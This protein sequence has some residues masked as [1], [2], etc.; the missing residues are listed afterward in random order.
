ME[1]ILKKIRDQILF[2][3][4]SNSNVHEGEILKSYYYV[5]DEWLKDYKSYRQNSPHLLHTFEKYFTKSL[6]Y[7]LHT[8]FNLY[9]AVLTFPVSKKF[10][11]SIIDIEPTD[12]S[13]ENLKKILEGSLS[14]KPNIRIS[15]IEIDTNGLSNPEIKEMISLLI[16]KLQ[17]DSI[18]NLSWDLKQVDSSVFDLVYLRA[19]CLKIGEAELFYH[20]SNIFVDRLFTSEFFQEARDLCEEI[21]IASIKDNLLYYGF[22]ICFRVYSNQASVQASLLY[23]NLFLNAVLK[24]ESIASDKFQFEIIW[25]SLKFFR[26]CSFYP[27]AIQVYESLPEKISLSTYER[28]SLDSSYFACRLS[29]KDATVTASLYDYLNKERE[30]ILAEGVGSCIPWLMTLYNLKRIKQVFDFEN[31]G[32]ES[33]LQLF[34]NIVP[35][36]KIEKYRNIVFGNSKELKKQLK[37]SL[38]KLART[39]NKSDFVYDNDM[40]I[41]IASRLV[42]TSFENKDIEA[43]L[44]AMLVKSDFSVSFLGKESQELAPIELTEINHE[45]FYETYN[46]PIETLKNFPLTETDSVIWLVGSEDKLFQATYHKNDFILNQFE[47][48]NMID[49]QKW[50]REILP[51]LEFDTSEKGKDGSV[52]SL[53][54]ED[55]DFQ[56]QNI[57]KEIAFP[58]L[59]NA[60]AL[61][62]LLLVKDMVVSELPHNL[63]LDETNELISLNASITNIL[64]VEWLNLKLNEKKQIPTNDKSIY[65]PTEGGDLTINMLFE[66]I[67]DTLEKH[68]VATVTTVSNFSPINSTI[69]IVSSHGD[70][71]ISSTQVFYPDENHVIHNLNGILGE[72]KILV[73]LVCHSG[74][75]K[76]FFFRNEIA[77]L[78][79]RYLSNGYEAVVAPFW[80]LHINIPPLWLPT[81]LSEIDEGKEVSEAVFTANKYVYDVYPTP[82]AWICMHLFGNP[83][84]SIPQK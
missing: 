52:R 66:F 38:L 63:L 31:S 37:E 5:L 18:K 47:S 13:L 73:L 82:A 26:N 21:L 22:F 65:I 33:Y 62:R 75:E 41:K 71:D 40:A 42:E 14:K 54:K 25:Q 32:L 45:V 23:G 77:S 16:G 7:S 78:I 9:D 19:L 69:N 81:F 56:S 57:I 29:M 60:T 67:K 58:K 35:K 84:Y 53:F 48:W 36:E 44:I 3:T 34:E 1:N 79:K 49:F 59:K 12:K 43:I 2:E 76:E 28:H 80:S 8:Y 20:A 72:G 51:K 70:R 15:D 17:R 6:S 4:V 68:N 83:F 61:Q 11:S 27:W 46:N 24:N 55:Y 39:R 64:S 30:N 74:S 50:C 10:D